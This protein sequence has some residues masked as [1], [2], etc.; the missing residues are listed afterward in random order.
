MLG[1]GRGCRALCERGLTLTTAP[2]RRGAGSPAPWRGPQPGTPRP[3][4][5]PRAFRSP[6][7]PVASP[8][9]STLPAP[10]QPRPASARFPASLR[11]S[12]PAF[13]RL[14]PGWSP[15][16]LT[17]PQPAPGTASWREDQEEGGE[18]IARGAGS[19]DAS[20]VPGRAGCETGRW[21]RRGKRQAT[22][23]QPDRA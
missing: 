17:P 23:L 18:W 3:D 7:H 8:A 12:R 5:P 13:P 14:R 21:R 19:Q 10:S 16:T 15:P 22:R 9:A 2:V 11:L 6:A 20:G 1:K 4:P